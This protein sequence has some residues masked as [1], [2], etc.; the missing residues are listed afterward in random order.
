MRRMGL[1]GAVLGMAMLNGA[2]CGGAARGS[3]PSSVAPAPAAPSAEPTESAPLALELVESSPIETDLDHDDLRN[4][5]VVW[6][7][8]IRGAQ[9]TIDIA[10]F[11]ASGR[12]GSRLELVVEEI[13][14]AADRGVAVRLLLEESF[15][16]EYPGLPDRFAKH[17]RIEVVRFDVGAKMGG[18]LH[19]KYFV[20]DG[21]EAFFGSQNFDWRALEHIQELGLRV[22][23]P[24]VV[25]A[26]A[27]L[28]ELDWRLATGAPPSVRRGGAPRSFRVEDG[29]YDVTLAMS[30]KGFL[31]DDADWD[32]PQIV[33]LVDGAER[34]I[35]VQLLSFRSRFYDGSPFPTLEDALRRAAS[36][37][38]EVKLLLADW[39]D[40]PGDIEPLRTLSNA[41]HIEVRLVSI[42]A[43]SGGEI[44]FARVIHAKYMVVDG[45]RAWLGTSNWSGDY[46]HRSR[47][48][49][50]VVRGGFL[51]PRLAA[52]FMDGW[53]SGYARSVTPIANDGR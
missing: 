31:L 52:F 7:E 17:P 42:P 29:A 48:V 12:E 13:E 9:R 19:A 33:E 30:P 2:A 14:R 24:G 3:T 49:G 44:P 25:Q 34:D 38:V 10:E 16:D 41:A 18:V 37:G 20:V 47:N 50:L 35:V 36:R 32:L 46:F 21:R 27:E 6:L 4:A 23:I 15:Y 8:M 5:D 40:E 28:F 11:Y 53:Q 43:W 26:L 1:G 51:A 22:R 45:V 39:N